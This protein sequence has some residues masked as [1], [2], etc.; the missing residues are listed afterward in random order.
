MEKK[1]LSDFKEI[2][3]MEN[4]EIHLSDKFREYEKWDSLAYLSLIAMMDEEFGVQI[5]GNEFKMLITIHDL[6]NAIN[7]KNK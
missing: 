4:E 2:L 6:I 5:E 1:F 3:E 7:E